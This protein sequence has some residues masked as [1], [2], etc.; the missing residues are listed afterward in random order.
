MGVF[1]EE[2]VSTRNTR[3][4]LGMVRVGTPRSLRL[5]VAAGIASTI[6]LMGVGLALP[7]GR[8]LTAAGEV[9]THDRGEAT[10][11][12]WIN[13]SAV[14]DVHPGMAARV[15]YRALPRG[16]QQWD[17]GVVT[18]VS[19]V[20]GQGLKR[21]L[22]RVGIQVSPSGRMDGRDVS[23]GM[24]VDVRMLEQRRPM[25]HWVLAGLTQ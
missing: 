20:P 2:V 13:E 17:D 3:H 25:Y 9:L 6:L 7:Y 14:P 8:S 4:A 1:R 12:S 5:L 19:R 21:G 16:V 10:V 23:A 24:I 11:Q 18:D 15:H 22:Y